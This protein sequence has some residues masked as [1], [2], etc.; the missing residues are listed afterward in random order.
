M[1]YN[2]LVMSH[3]NYHSIIWS[4]ESNDLKRLVITQ[5]RVIRSICKSP[6]NSHTEP[7]F[8]KAR[9]LKLKHILELNILKLG[10]KILH[11][12]EPISVRE[13]FPGRKKNNT[14]LDDLPLLEIPRCKTNAEKRLPQYRIATTWNFAVKHYTFNMTAKPNTMAKEFKDTMLT[15]YEYF[16]CENSKCYPCQRPVRGIS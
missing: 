12:I 16:K 8:C 14:R 5:K 13:I 2:S 7:L 3:C 10:S 6:Y 11:K 15:H 9:T 1:L 4:C